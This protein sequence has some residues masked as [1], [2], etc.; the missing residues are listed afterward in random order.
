M[1]FA[2]YVHSGSLKEE[3]LFYSPLSTTTKASD[4]LEKVV[5]FFETENLS[6][7][8]L[9]RCCTGGASAMMGSR[10]GFQVLVKNRSPNIKCSHC[11]IYRQAL[12]SKTLP[13][14][15]ATV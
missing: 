6:W 5:S 11:M 9:Y 1:V 10:S 14:S 4:I 2:R 12:A 3:F 8:N 7:N 15:F 13:V